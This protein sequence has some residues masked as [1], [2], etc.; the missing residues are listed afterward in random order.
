MFF[1][2]RKAYHKLSLKVHPDRVEE[3]EKAEATEKFKVLA[4]IHSIL[5]CKE[6]RAI[7]DETGCIDEEDH[8][9]GDFDWMNY[10]KAVFKPISEKDISEYEK[11]YK[12]SS[13]EAMDLKKA[14]LNGKGD[15][16]FIYETV[17]F[18][19]CDEEPRLRKIIEGFIAD[20]SVPEYD[21]FVNEPS[22]KAA[23]RK[24]KVIL[25]FLTIFYCGISKLLYGCDSFN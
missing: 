23:R 12:N 24:R 9:F 19:N 5:N 17:P 7:Y 3:S 20:G 14:Y 16:D 6:K 4:K 11:N 2:V 13:V 8:I 25:L 1:S 21:L 15:M 22:K 18:T 10:W